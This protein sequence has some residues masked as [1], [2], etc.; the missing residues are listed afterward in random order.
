MAGKYDAIVGSI[1]ITAARQ[2]AVD[3]V[4]PYYRPDTSF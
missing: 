4:G 1:T 3:F 2:K